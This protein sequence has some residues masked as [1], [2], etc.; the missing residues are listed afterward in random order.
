MMAMVVAGRRGK[1]GGHRGRGAT[2]GGARG[3]M[4]DDGGGAR[5]DPDVR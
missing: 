5:K 2:V 4:V 1:K 3:T